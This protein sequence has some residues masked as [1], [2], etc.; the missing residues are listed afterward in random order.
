M[1]NPVFAWYTDLRKSLLMSL[2]LSTV[3]EIPVGYTTRSTCMV[4]Y[5]LQSAQLEVSARQ[6]QIQKSIQPRID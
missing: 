2:R 5:K 4:E 6:S 1:K 3:M